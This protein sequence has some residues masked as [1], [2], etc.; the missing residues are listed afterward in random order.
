M[1]LLIWLFFV[2]L[3]LLMLSFKYNKVKIMGFDNKFFSKI[4]NR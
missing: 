3:V 4:K 2:F 1:D